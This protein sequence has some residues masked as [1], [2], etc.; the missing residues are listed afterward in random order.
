[1]DPGARM[2]V[3]EIDAPASVV[4]SRE[5]VGQHRI[6]GARLKYMYVP[7]RVC[8]RGSDNE[9]A[10]LIVFTWSCTVW[11]GLSFFLFFSF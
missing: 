10:F 9:D 5:V 2:R 1:M 3:V 11:S 6:G 4:K 8:G 7:T